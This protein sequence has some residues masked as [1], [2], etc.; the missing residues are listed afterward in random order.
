MSH[1]GKMRRGKQDVE[2]DMDTLDAQY[3]LQN[4]DAVAEAIEAAD[5]PDTDQPQKKR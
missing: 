1:D 2:R 3:Y 4:R 5:P